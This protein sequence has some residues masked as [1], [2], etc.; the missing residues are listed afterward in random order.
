MAD[1]LLFPYSGSTK[2]PPL[3]F[4]TVQSANVNNYDKDN[5]DDND[6]NDDGDNDDDYDD[7]NKE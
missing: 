6:S 1:L 5:D 2:L 7:N 3:N 4:L